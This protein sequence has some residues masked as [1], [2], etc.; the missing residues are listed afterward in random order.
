MDIDI[1]SLIPNTKNT[2]KEE[3]NP[4]LKKKEQKKE[5]EPK[6]NLKENTQAQKETAIPQTKEIPVKVSPENIKSASVFLNRGTINL[7]NKKINEAISDFTNAIQLNPNDIK[8]F[9][10]RADCYNSINNFD[11]AIEDLKKAISILPDTSLSYYKIAVT[12]KLK[13][14]I[15]N[16]IE[17]F[18]KAIELNPRNAMAYFEY[19]KLCEQKGLIDFAIDNYSKAASLDIKIAKECNMNIVKLKKSK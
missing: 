18:K 8:G 19:A 9:L 11:L 16:S 2:P 15:D 4:I 10:L 17:Y 3:T 5:E 7:K 12:Y 6:Q 13:N 14:D 1:E